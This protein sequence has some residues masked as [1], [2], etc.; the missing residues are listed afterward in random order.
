M[1]NEFHM[2]VFEGDV[3]RV[4]SEGE[5]ATLRRLP[6]MPVI[7]FVMH[8]IHQMQCSALLCMLRS[9]CKV[10]INDRRADPGAGIPRKQGR[11]MICSNTLI[12]CRQ[13]CKAGAYDDVTL[14]STTLRSTACGSEN[15][16]SPKIRPV[17][18][19]M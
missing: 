17:P 19:C 8:V 10:A 6:L 4:P 9:L 15:Y 14:R 1:Q 5:T 18:Q 11:R 13:V 2:R 12:S 7:R 16:R 3:L